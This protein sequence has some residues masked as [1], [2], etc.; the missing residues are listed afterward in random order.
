MHSDKRKPRYWNRTVLNHNHEEAPEIFLKSFAIPNRF[1][2]IPSSCQSVQQLTLH[3]RETKRRLHGQRAAGLGSVNAGSSSMSRVAATKHPRARGS[4][5]TQRESDRQRTSRL[6]NIDDRAGCLSRRIF[7]FARSPRVAARCH[8]LCSRPPRVALPLALVLLSSPLAG[9]HR[10]TSAQLHAL[11]ECD[12][13]A[14][15]R[16]R[17][18]LF[19]ILFGCS[20]CSSSAPSPPRSRVPFLLPSSAI[21]ELRAFRIYERFSPNHCL[22][23]S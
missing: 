10:L 12:S 15:R 3:N 19:F 11:L 20:S 4:C 8:C 23:P 2:Y 9:V 1:R 17:D 6:K 14:A 7:A 21:F 22:L 18:G 13:E 5:A 16:E